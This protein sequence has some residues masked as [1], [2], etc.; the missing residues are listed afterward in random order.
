MSHTNATFE[1]NRNK[2]RE[3]QS[4]AAAEQAR[5]LKGKRQQ[6]AHR[7]ARHAAADSRTLESL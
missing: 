6:Q 5:Y 1:K 3:T 4:H 2:Q 7:T